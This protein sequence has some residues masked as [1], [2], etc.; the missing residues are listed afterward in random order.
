[1]FS[2]PNMR[3]A[4]LSALFSI[5]ALSAHATPVPV[6]KQSSSVFGSNGSAAVT[7]TDDIELPSGLSTLAGGFDLSSG[8]LGDF[9]A[10]CLDISTYLRLSSNYEITEDSAGFDPFGTAR[11]TLAQKFNV[12]ALFNTGFS[13]LDL[14]SDADS[15]G[16]QLAL[17][18]VTYEDSGSFDVNSGDFNVTGNSAARTRANQ[19]LGGINGPKTQ[20]Y[21]LTFLESTDTYY[22]SHKSQH[23]VTA[24]P[25]PL[26]AAGFLL[27]G[28]LGGLGFVGK[29]RK[30]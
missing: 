6:S 28:A 8:P 22:G 26:P 19:L 20:S 18:E 11:P 13:S 2:S 17:W 29:R 10:W 14:T 30:G 25:I 16:F 24:S 1:M 21:R 4:T 12:Q 3:L 9:V 7:I 15:A 23:L 5:A 27:L